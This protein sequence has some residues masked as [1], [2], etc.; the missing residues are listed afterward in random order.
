MY[1]I[2][3]VEDDRAISQLYQIKFKKEGYTVEVAENGK[4]GLVLAEKMKPDVV[5][6]DLMMPEMTGGEMLKVL[7]KTEWGKD[8]K[9]V[10]LT[11]VSVDEAE[12][13][14]KGQNIQ[15]FILKAHYTPQQVVDTVKKVLL[16]K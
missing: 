14:I 10:I 5:L 11:N 3:I 4:D 6:L 8:V 15:G 1:K 13:E 9:V 7:R 2:A 16:Q 12:P